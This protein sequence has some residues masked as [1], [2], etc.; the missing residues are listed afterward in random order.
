MTDGELGRFVDAQAPVYAAVEA[1]LRAGRKTS[2]WMWFVFPQ[3]AGL[4]M[5]AMSQRYAIQS[6]AE[7]AA[8]LEHPLLGPRLRDGVALVLASGRT[9]HEVFGDPD[10]AKF[11]SCCT[12]FEAVAGEASVFGTVLD[13]LYGG[14]RHVET[15]RRI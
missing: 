14:M 4:A 7:A 12:L 3:I 8:Y 11:H 13:Q 5:S 1:E 15:L 2:H 9:A 10:T 6:R